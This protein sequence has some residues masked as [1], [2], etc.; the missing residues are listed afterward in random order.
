MEQVV[1]SSCDA[2]P[3]EKTPRSWLFRSLRIGFPIVICVVAVAAIPV[4]FVLG[5][6]VGN[7]Q[8]YSN[9]SERQKARIEAYLFENPEAFADL[10]VEH[11][12]NGWAFPIGSVGTQ[13]DYDDLNA[14]LHE[15]FG[16]EL[17]VRMMNTIEVDVSK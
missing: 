15:M 5:A 16:D 7:T 9:F 14:K 4:A 13:G 10:S 11:A 3:S 1:T 8:V 12:S 17:A 2:L 6:V